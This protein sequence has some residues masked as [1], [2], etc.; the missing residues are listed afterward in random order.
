MKHLTA[1]LATIVLL[2]I[3]LACSGDDREKANGLV[4]EANKFVA[5]AN[6]S[7]KKAEA[8]GNEYDARL[9]KITKDSELNE[10]R[11]FGKEI[12]KLYDTIKDNFDKAGAKF[13][14]ASKLNINDKAKEYLGI[15]GNEMKKRGEYS[16]EI[17]RIPQAL[18]DSKKKEEYVADAQKYGANAKKLLEEA[19][20]M[21]EKA[22]KLA[23]D[24]PTLI[25]SPGN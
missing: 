20:E 4:S 11:E 15:K 17:K 5:E 2:V 23:N 14:E 3:G 9:V 19:N 7:V 8:K 16:A 25:T 22:N 13:E 24:N 21:A 6:D 12:I 10:L 18:I 1:V